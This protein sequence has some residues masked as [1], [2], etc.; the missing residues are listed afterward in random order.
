[1]CNH[2]QLAPLKDTK[3]Y[4]LDLGLPLQEP[5]FEQEELEIFPKRTAP[6]LLYADDKLQL[7]PKS[8]GF[9]S[10]YKKNQVIF[11]ARI[12]RFYSPRPSMWDES[13]ARLR[14]IILAKDFLEKKDRKPTLL[15]VQSRLR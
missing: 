7:V 12:E 1:M 11:N 5:K 2:F 14:C 10:P 9:P 13:F 8:W 4:L 15:R 3:K 6:V